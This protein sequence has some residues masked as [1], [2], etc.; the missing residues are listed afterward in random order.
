MLISVLAELGA[1]GIAEGAI[2]DAASFTSGLCEG[3]S[4]TIDPDVDVVMVLIHELI[5]RLH[6]AWGERRVD[7]MTMALARRLSEAQLR[8]IA[9]EYHKRKVI[10]KRPKVVD[11]S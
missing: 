3:R 7:S 2:H 1:G 5:H 10:R 8:Q 6:P 4:V 9:A 11:L